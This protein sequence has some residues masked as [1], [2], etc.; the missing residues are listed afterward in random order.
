MI[1]QASAHQVN[2]ADCRERIRY[3]KHCPSH[4]KVEASSVVRGYQYAPIKYV[5]IEASEL[6]KLR[7][8]RKRPCNW[9]S[10]SMPTRSTP[11]CSL[12]AAFTCF[13]ISQSEICLDPPPQVASVKGEAHSAIAE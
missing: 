7:R 13:P 4:G 6:D 8:P 9:S 2:N 11:P 10:S 12:V 1:A 5:V 3:E